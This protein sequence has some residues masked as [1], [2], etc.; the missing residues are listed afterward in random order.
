MEPIALTERPRSQEI[1]TISQIY[2][3][4]PSCGLDKPESTSNPTSG[5]HLRFSKNMRTIIPMSL[6][7]GSNPEAPQTSNYSTKKM[8]Q[9]DQ[10]NEILN[11][12]S[13]LLY[14]KAIRGLIRR[15]NGCVL[16]EIKQT[17]EIDANGEKR[18]KSEIITRKQI[19][20]DLSAIIF[21]LTNINPDKWSAKPSNTAS[22]L[23]LDEEL[24]D[25]S[26]LSEQTLREML[27]EQT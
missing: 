7:S 9:D 10:Q 11:K 22:E 17:V 19:A 20:P 1:T 4:T 24:I 26:S 14:E 27:N 18:I 21:A 13:V 12:L 23:C 3:G 16:K 15:V 2:E 25:L 5:R 8:K 6:P